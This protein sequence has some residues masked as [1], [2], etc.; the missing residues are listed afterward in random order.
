MDYLATWAKLTKAPDEAR[1]LAGIDG[2]SLAAAYRARV[3]FARQFLQ[4]TWRPL[5]QQTLVGPVLLEPSLSETQRCSA[6]YGLVDDPARLFSEMG[7]TTLEPAQC[8]AFRTV[9][10]ELFAMVVALV[11]AE[12]I[13]RRAAKKSY[14]V[15][16]RQERVLRLLY[17]L[18]DDTAVAALPER[19]P[20]PPQVK[21]PPPSASAEKL[22]TP[23]D[24]VAGRI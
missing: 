2:P 24:R 8:D 10:P 14:Q 19:E 18:A 5:T 9:Y 7:A 23:A 22:Q 1:L 12:L 17:G 20:P 4:A 6:V 15:P 13:K 16:Y 11:D 3:L 21:V